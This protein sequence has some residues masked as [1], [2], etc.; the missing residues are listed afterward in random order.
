MVEGGLSQTLEELNAILR[1]LFKHKIVVGVSLKKVSGDVDI[2]EEVNV[3]EDQFE[4]YEKMY[5]T[6]DKQECKLT[7][8]NT[9][10]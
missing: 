6:V 1:T 10:S 4:D 2:W 9:K 3:N 7:L 5:Y 8:K